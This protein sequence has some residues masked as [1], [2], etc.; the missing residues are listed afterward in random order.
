[1]TPR[2]DRLSPVRGR[3]A[4]RLALALSVAGAATATSA[5][6]QEAG[7][8]PSCA[9][10]WLAHVTAGSAVR[11]L[12]RVAELSHPAPRGQR[13]T[14]LI[15]QSRSH[16]SCPG[17]DALRWAMPVHDLTLRALPVTVG[18][19]LNTGYAEDR[20][21][22]LV[23][24]GRGW[25]SSLAG[26]VFARWGAVSA[27]FVP[28]VAWQENREF[29]VV[30]RS[31]PGFSPWIHAHYT[32]IDLPQRFGDDSFTTLDL[33]GQSFLRVDVR[34]FAAG[35]SHE[36]LVIGPSIRNPILIGGSG[37]GFH[38]LFAGTARPLD[39]GPVRA[40]A[41]AFLGHLSES[42]Y[43]DERPSNN[44]SSIS[45]LSFSL[46]PDFFPGLEIGAAKLVTGRSDPSGGWFVNVDALGAVF[47]AG[48]P[49]ARWHSMSSLFARFVFPEERAEIYGEWARS[50]PAAGIADLIQEPDHG[51][52]YTFGFQKVTPIADGG[53]RVQAEWTALQ[54]LGEPREGRPLV[55]YYT[56]RNQ[57]QGHTQRGQMLGA[58]IGPG[59]D[60]QFVAADWLA[61]RGYGGIFVERV[62]RNDASTTAHAERVWF[63]FDHDAALT[64]G[65]R[66]LVLLGP[67]SIAGSL[68]YSRRYSRDFLG[69]D[70]NV[71]LVTELVWWP[72]PP[73][74]GDAPWRG[75]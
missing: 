2:A 51:Q 3:A 23:W 68:S 57:I 30:P 66:G 12:E 5:A 61:D 17:T 14:H 29:D 47:T 10:T 64:G 26:G 15:R 8:A 42:D 31:L 62:R 13:S 19:W 69:D 7:A 33:V 59:S 67:I 4:L 55:V 74:A 6:G 75:R 22:G 72:T 50:G 71:Q 73:R 56:H 28:E 46:R 36:S 65:V 70:S 1:M 18:T 20:N 58:G 25:S 40:E 63:P 16:A 27:A 37:P 60:A 34:G 41:Q 44:R 35:Y 21:N 11:D 32:A 52:G 43:F 9:T 49:D 48:D 24:A 54:E 38:H 45:G 53:L 39:L